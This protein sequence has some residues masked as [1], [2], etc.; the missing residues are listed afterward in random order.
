MLQEEVAH[1]V[2]HL[3]ALLQTTCRRGRQVGVLADRVVALRV[4][5]R[6][7]ALIEASIL[8]LLFAVV[9]IVET[10]EVSLAND[11]GLVLD[12]Y[13]CLPALSRI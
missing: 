5:Q 9:E 6:V 13:V 2:L 3:G 11:L 1:L 4:S 12:A 10:L 7:R 8:Q